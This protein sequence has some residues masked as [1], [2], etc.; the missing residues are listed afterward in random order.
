MAA[1]YLLVGLKKREKSASTTTQ[2]T[3]WKLGTSILLLALKRNITKHLPQ[4]MFQI[5][6]SGEE[7]RTILI[8]PPAKKCPELKGAR[9]LSLPVPSPCIFPQLDCREALGPPQHLAR[10]SCEVQCCFVTYSGSSLWKSFYFCFN[11][12]L[13]PVSI[14]QK[15][16]Q[17]CFSI[18]FYFLGE[19]TGEERGK[20]TGF[21][22]SL[23]SV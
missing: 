22:W 17:H 23:Q 1:G 7:D 10:G 6:E 4:F 16:H 9:A 13:Y 19:R 8:M 5:K 2:P 3:S 21:H 14:I 12:I 18:A 11:S 15:S 20:K